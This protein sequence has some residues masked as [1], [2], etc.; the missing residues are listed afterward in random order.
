MAAASQEKYH[1]QRVKHIGSANSCTKFVPPS[2][3]RSFKSPK[4]TYVAEPQINPKQ[5]LRQHQT[6][7]CGQLSQILEQSQR[8]RSAMAETCSIDEEQSFDGYTYEF[9]CTPVNC[10]SKYGLEF[11]FSQESNLCIFASPSPSP[12]GE[13]VASPSPQGG[14]DTGSASPCGQHGTLACTSPGG[15]SGGTV[16]QGSICFCLCAEGWSNIHPGS[17]TGTAV[18]SPTAGT[19][20]TDPEADEGSGATS[21][22]LRPCIFTDGTSGVAGKN[23]QQ[24]L[25][26]DSSCSGFSCVLN[27]SK[28][29]ISILGILAIVILICCLSCKPCRRAAACI[30]CRSKERTQDYRQRRRRRR[31]S[32]WSDFKHQGN[33]AYNSKRRYS[34]NDEWDSRRSTAFSAYAG[35]SRF[36][37]SNNQYSNRHHGQSALQHKKHAR[38]H[39]Q[40]SLLHTGRKVRRQ[41]SPIQS[42]LGRQDPLADSAAHPH[43]PT[44]LSPTHAS[45]AN[46]HAAQHAVVGIP[47]PGV[48]T[49]AQGASAP[50]QNFQQSEYSGQAADPC[51]YSQQVYWDESGQ[52]W[53]DDGSQEWI[54]AGEN[55]L[56]LAVAANSAAS[57]PGASAH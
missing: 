7:F 43:N 44:E 33:I 21:S 46:F 3:N 49:T 22:S 18:P 29:V 20:S 8:F 32:S 51:T 17:Q 54:W 48:V 4:T 5:E 26:G 42:S 10:K 13:T 56:A 16:V 41:Q 31:E 34:R 30:K 2:S 11:V 39:R 28:Y 27:D 38:M 14:S 9:V 50:S 24:E 6:L 19:Q 55:G 1:L 40:S 15:A 37:I 25:P 47:E 53:W 52:Y 45:G 35:P 36:S 12:R 23:G 57:D